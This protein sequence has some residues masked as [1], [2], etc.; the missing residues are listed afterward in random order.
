MARKGGPEQSVPSDQVRGIHICTV[1][2]QDAD[3]IRVPPR[4]R[5]HQ[6][7]PPVLIFCIGIC[8]PREQLPNFGRIPGPGGIREFCVEVLRE[9]GSGEA[10]DYRERPQCSRHRDFKGSSQHPWSASR[11]PVPHEV[12]PNEE[13][14]A[15]TVSA[16]NNSIAP[17]TKSAQ[18]MVKLGECITVRPPFSPEKPLPC[19]SHLG[20][21]DENG[22]PRGA[23]ESHPCRLEGDSVPGN[24]SASH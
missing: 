19:R 14:K 12:E 18:G 2:Q 8:A 21:C 20:L 15:I 6:R 4:R 16:A 7:R 1:F 5:F 9:G 22:R 24:F 23:S 11:R 13:Y 17:G 10:K 3:V